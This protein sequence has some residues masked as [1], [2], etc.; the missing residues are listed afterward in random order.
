M[1]FYWGVVYALSSWQLDHLSKVMND[2][3]RVLNV[4]KHNKRKFL[5]L[6]Q[7]AHWAVCIWKKQT[8][9]RNE[10]RNPFSK[11]LV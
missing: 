10:N 8:L 5:K 4:N 7:C 6:C 9:Q 3:I 11:N 2:Q 1:G